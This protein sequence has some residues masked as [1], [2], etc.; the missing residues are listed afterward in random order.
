MG[1]DNG[2]KEERTGPMASLVKLSTAG[3]FLLGVAYLMG[4]VV[5]NGYQTKYLNYSANVLQLRHLAAGLL[6]AFLTLVQVSLIAFL[7]LSGVIEVKFTSFAKPK[8]NQTK[9]PRRRA[10]LFSRMGRFALYAGFIGRSLLSG[11]LVLFLFFQFIGMSFPPNQSGTVLI[12]KAMLPWSAINLALSIVIMSIIYIG[13]TRGLE[14]GV[15]NVAAPEVLKGSK[16]GL[17]SAQQLEQLKKN[18]IETYASKIILPGLLSVLL[19]FSL[20]SFQP[21]YGRLRPDYGGG[22]LYTVSLHLKS[23]TGLAPEVKARLQSSD[24]WLFLVDKDGT[25]VNVL[26]VDKSGNRQLLGI[27]QGEIEALEILSTPPISPADA[28]FFMQ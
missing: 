26:R 16:E 3:L 9:R 23:S 19:L 4:F 7:L 28:P 10:R 21:L 25:F 6:Y 18:Y 2:K 5:V 14:K 1:E 22:A 20:V 15:Q 17:V 8:E 27:S 24:S 13:G 11:Y 12:I